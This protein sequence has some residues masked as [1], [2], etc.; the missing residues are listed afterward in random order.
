MDGIE[1]SKAKSYFTELNPKPDL[2]ILQRSQYI[3]NKIK[4]LGIDDDSFAY[5]GSIVYSKKLF[6]LVDDKLPKF[7]R[8]LQTCIIRCLTL[9][10]KPEI[11]VAWF[12]NP[13]SYKCLESFHTTLKT[14][15]S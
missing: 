6:K 7:G 13:I 14:G 10:G 1:R 5:S 9:I 12:R 15:Q 2:F 11:V 8:Q 3:R 4:L